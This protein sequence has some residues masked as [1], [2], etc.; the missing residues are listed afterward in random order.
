MAAALME[1]SA[2]DIEFKSGTYTVVGTD[3]HMS[4]SD[5]ARA[6]FARPAR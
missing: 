1:A 2:A 5:V 6:F 4:I 3:K